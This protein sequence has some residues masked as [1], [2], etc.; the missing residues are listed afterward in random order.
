MKTTYLLTAALAGALTAIAPAPAAAQGSGILGEDASACTNGQ[1]PAIRATITGL[2]DRSGRL[3]LELYPGNEDDFLKDDRDLRSE[4]KF[5]R[6]VWADT[7]ESGSVVLCIKAPSPGSYALFF[8][9]DRDG[10]NKFNFWRDGAGFA[11]PGNLGRSRPR[12]EQALV[13]V[14]SGVTNVTIRAQYLRG[15]AG[16]RTID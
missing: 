11:K 14:G 13:N 5:F 7:P 15:V 10:K 8:T 1:G 12:L 4:G 6:R 3:K 2:R 9:H 16:F